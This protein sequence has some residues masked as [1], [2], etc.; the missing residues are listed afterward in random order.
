M[1]VNKPNAMNAMAGAKR[2]ITGRGKPARL[3]DDEEQDG[4]EMQGAADQDK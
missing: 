4:K 2:T 1:D 3:G